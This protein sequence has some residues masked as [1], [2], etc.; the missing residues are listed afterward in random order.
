MDLSIKPLPTSKDDIEQPYLSELKIIPKINSR[1]IFVGHSG[2]GK[3]TLVANILTREDM[4]GNQFDRRILISPTASTDDIQ[5]QLDFQKQ[6]IVEDL[7]KAPQ[8]LENL[9]KELRK[10]IEEKSASGA[11][12]V[13]V[14]FEDVAS[15]DELKKSKAFVDSFILCRHFNF[16]TFVCTQS[17]KM[18]PKKC[19]LQA[20]NIFFFGGADSEMRVLAEDRSP[21]MFSMRMMLE[22]IK[23][24]TTEKHSFLHINMEAPVA[25]RYRKNLDEIYPI[26]NQQNDDDGDHT[27]TDQKE[28]PK[29]RVQ[30]KSNLSY[31]DIQQTDSKSKNYKLSG[32]TDGKKFL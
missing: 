24:A 25:E 4:L 26:S 21:P 1:S 10:E 18:I 23:N 11:S 8:F 32:S 14:Y 29:V 7:H 12:K 6:D 3:S 2:S 31:Q 27:S 20:T 19:R 22:L 30:D 17:Y 15:A 5:K 16:T 13:L 28:G 9:Q